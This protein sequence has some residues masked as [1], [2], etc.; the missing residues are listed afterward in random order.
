MGVH[1]VDMDPQASLTRT[2]GEEDPP[3]R[4]YFSLCDRTG[5][6]VNGIGNNLTLSPIPEYP[7]FQ[8]RETGFEPAT[9]SLGS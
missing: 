9:S 1:L 8:E 6:P 2:F 7:C 5:L 3:D 4:L